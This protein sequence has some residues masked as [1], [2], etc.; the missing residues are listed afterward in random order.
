VSLQPTPTFK[1]IEQ[2]E[3]IEQLD[4]TRKWLDSKKG[5][6]AS[7]ED[8]AGLSPFLPPPT[9]AHL[10]ALSRAHS[11]LLPV[12]PA[13]THAS[14]QIGKRKSKKYG[15]LLYRKPTRSKP[16]HAPTSL[17]YITSPPPLQ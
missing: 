14:A 12:L 4:S 2:E 6:T 10:R 5:K 1:T 13:L 8:F 9:L 7:D 16:P 3:M 11:L 15:I 17:Q